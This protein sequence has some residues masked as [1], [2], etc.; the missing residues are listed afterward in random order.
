MTEV[1]FKVILTNVSFFCEASVA[2][3]A[4]V[5]V[6]LVAQ[7][8]TVGVFFIIIITAIVLRVINSPE[9][10]VEGKL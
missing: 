2:A 9:V 1:I 6:Q 7:L 5:D 10:D 3:D 8:L 4:A